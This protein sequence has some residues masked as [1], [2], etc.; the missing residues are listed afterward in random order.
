MRKYG[1]GKIGAVDNI[2]TNKRNK[3]LEMKLRNSHLYVDEDVSKPS[4]SHSVLNLVETKDEGSCLRSTDSDI[5]KDYTVQT[6]KILADEN[7]IKMHCNS[8]QPLWCFRSRHCG[9]RIQCF[10]RLWRCYG[11]RFYPCYR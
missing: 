1:I 3:A 11:F 4:C 8:Q 7:K 9:D 6:E 5:D 10:V 2:E